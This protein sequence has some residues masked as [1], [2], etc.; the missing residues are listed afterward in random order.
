M[1]PVSDTIYVQSGHCID[2][3]ALRSGMNIF[4]PLFSLPKVILISAARSLIEIQS[5]RIITSR[6]NLPV[7]HNWPLDC[8]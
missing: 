3:N 6:Y 4:S 7:N 5:V 1:P 2:Y 8:V